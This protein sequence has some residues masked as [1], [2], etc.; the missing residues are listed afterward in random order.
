MAKLPVKI[1]SDKERRVFVEDQSLSDT[2]PVK[3]YQLN[4]TLAAPFMRDGKF[5]FR[6][7]F[8]R[9]QDDTLKF[10]ERTKCPIIQISPEEVLQTENE[11]AQRMLENFIVPTNT[12]RNGAT[13]EAGHLFVDVTATETEYDVDLDAIFDSV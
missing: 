1:A 10:F 2:I 13:R 6:V 3:L 5:Q 7:A 8:D 9:I 12:V 11:T 4:E